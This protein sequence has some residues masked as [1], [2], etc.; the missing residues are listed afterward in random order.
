MLLDGLLNILLQFRQPCFGRL[1]GITDIAFR[2]RQQVPQLGHFFFRDVFEVGSLFCQKLTGLRVDVL[3]T[4]GH[5]L[6]DRVEQRFLQVEQFLRCM[7]E[8]S[9]EVLVRLLCDTGDFRPSFFQ[10]FQEWKHSLLSN[11]ALKF[12]G[13]RRQLFGNLFSQS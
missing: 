7:A 13:S 12:G 8:L 5:K 3:H 11:K 6:P 2:I 9:K 1:H 10:S 4:A